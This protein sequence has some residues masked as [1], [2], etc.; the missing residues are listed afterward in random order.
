VGL[1]N[2]KDQITA[3]R[4]LR[5]TTVPVVPGDVYRVR[6][7]SARRFEASQHGGRSASSRRCCEI[8]KGGT[9]DGNF[10]PFASL[11]TPLLAPWRFTACT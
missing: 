10:D 4:T 7:E 1:L 5:P 2:I 8:G 11:S 3:R 6:S 9:V